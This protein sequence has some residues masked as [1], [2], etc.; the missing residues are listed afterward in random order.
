MRECPLHRL[1]KTDK[2]LILNGIGVV[3]EAVLQL[4]RDQGIPIAG[5]CDGSIKTVG[6]DFH[7]FSVIHTPLLSQQFL[8]ARIIISAAA[9]QDV[10]LT[11]TAQGLDDWIAAGSLLDDLDIAQ[12][13]AALDIRKFAIETCILAHAA[14]MQPDRA[15]LRSVDLIITERCSLKCRDC[16]NLMQ[17]YEQPR[18]VATPVLLRSLDTLDTTLDEV[19][20]LRIIGGDTFMNREWPIIVRHAS[21]KPNIRRVVVYTNGVIVPAESHAE[22]LKDALVVVTDY[23]SL[24]RRLHDLQGYLE[25]QGIAHRI[26]KPD[27]WLDCAGLNRHPKEK[28][29]QKFRACCA[30]NMPSLSEEKLFRCPF[31][32]N[33]HRLG[34]VPDEPEDW[35]D[36]F[37]ENA[38]HAIMRY[39][40]CTTPMTLCDFCNGRPLSGVEVPPAV[41]VD[42]PLS[43]TRYAS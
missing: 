11:L 7:G 12:P 18:N 13:D 3:G 14:W 29:D 37:S 39:V 41:Q 35:V 9:I 8:D 4:C 15:V 28:R 5:V 33:A 42:D 19:M 21:G 40:R 30:K 32:A 23:G 6:M 34:A 25:K 1:R 10:V 22:S 27:S 16:A 38:R 26:L 20:E 24:S 31:A 2:P 17:Y 43:Y 36:I